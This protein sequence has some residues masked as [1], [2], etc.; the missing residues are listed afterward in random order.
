MASQI[1][2]AQDRLSIAEQEQSI[3]VAQVRNAS[4]VSDFLTT[5]YTNAQLYSWMN[6]QLTTVYTQA[7]QLAY[8]YALQARPRTGSSSASTCPR[9]RTTSSSSATGTAS[10]GNHRGG[11]PALRLAADGGRLRREQ[12]AELELTKH[13]S[14]VMTAPTALV[15]LRET[16]TCTVNSTRPSSNTT[17]PGTTSQARS[18]AVTV[19]CVT[20]PYTGVNATLTLN[21]AMV[22]TQAAGQNYKP[23]RPDGEL[24]AGVTA[25]PGGAAGTETIVTSTGQQDAGLFEVNLRD[26]RWLPFEGQGAISTWTLTLDPRDN[27]FDF[28]TITDVILHVR[29]TARDGGNQAAGNVRNALNP[30]DRGRSWSVPATRSPTPGTRSSTLPRRRPGRR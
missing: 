21:S 27:N 4:A 16:C 6:T 5:K 3:A 25:S 29:Y 7:Y 15:E 12:R 18:V 23:Q 13:V 2:A 8:A 20:G 28:T 24:L 17:T 10:T 30:S 11:E 22:R 26:E 9:P 1:T 19:P 14:L